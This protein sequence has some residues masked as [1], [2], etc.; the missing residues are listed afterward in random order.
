M[1]VY[2]TDQPEQSINHQL[3]ALAA[4]GAEERCFVL[5]FTHRADYIVPPVTYALLSV[6]ALTTTAAGQVQIH[7]ALMEDSASVRRE[8]ETLTASADACARFARDHQLPWLQLNGPLQLAPVAIAKPWG[9]EIWYTGIEAR[10][11]AAVSAQGLTTPL[12][13]LLTLLPESVATGHKQGLIL[14]KILDPLAEEVFGDLYFEMHEQKQ[15][16]YI[17]TG[18]DQRAWPDGTGAIRLGFSAEVRGNYPHD[19]AFKQAYLDSVN[20][21][22]VV[23]AGIDRV[24]DAKR[25]ALG[26]EL[27]TPLDPTRLTGWLGELPPQLL[28]EEREK[29]R[30]MEQFSVLHSLHLGDVVKV[31]CRVPHALQHGVRTVEF[32]TPVYERKIL[33]FAQK[34]LTQP[35]WDTREALANILL[36]TPPQPPLEILYAD[37][38]VRVERVVVFEDFEVRRLHLRAHQSTKLDGRSHYSLVMLV[39]GRLT[40]CGKGMCLNAVDNQIQNEAFLLPIIG[41]DYDLVARDV[42]L[43]VLLAL[44]LPHSFG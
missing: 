12:P 21:Y 33:S 23:R 14:L 27:N 25:L 28:L 16:V 34:V 15:E 43:I 10:G 17:V 20:E 44:P 22:R 13:W 11:Q 30:A 26:I 2:T 9:Q 39:A 7:G 41:E 4:D 18:I 42:D 40:V 8:L 32:Q 38:T 19:E 36:E 1:D 29:R 24:L 37:D 3:A 6:I 31:P 35:D 5:A